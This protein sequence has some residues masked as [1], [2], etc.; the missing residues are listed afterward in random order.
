[1]AG[2]GLD[3]RQAADR[4]LAV[5][6][7]VLPLAHMPRSLAARDV[8]ATRSTRRPRR[9]YTSGTTRRSSE[10]CIL[11][12]METL[13]VRVENG[14]IIGT[15]PTGLPEGTELELCLADP[16]DE[17]TEE[18]R[19]ALDAALEAG[20]KSMIEGRSRPA[21]EAVAELRARK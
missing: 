4:G 11:I 8:A 1:V 17:M 21:R 7:A 9:G 3:E 5:D 12:D 15:A 19:M 14:K 6:V 10:P 13:R 20:W 2:V 18:E 16:A